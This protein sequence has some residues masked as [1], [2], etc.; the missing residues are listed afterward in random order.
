VITDLDAL[1]EQSCR[2]AERAIGLLVNGAPLCSLLAVGDRARAR[3]AAHPGDPVLVQAD[4]FFDTCTTAAED[5]TPTNAK[6]AYA[7][8]SALKATLEFVQAV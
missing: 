8:M 1:R 7:A 4:A 3:L 5:P 2:D 6:A